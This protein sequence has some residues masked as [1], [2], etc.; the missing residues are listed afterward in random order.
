MKGKG[1]VFQD[2]LIGKGIRDGGGIVHVLN[3]QREP[4][5]CAQV[6]V[7]R[8]GHCQC[9]EPT[10]LLSGD[11]AERAG[12]GIKAQPRGQIPSACKR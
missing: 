1:R 3:G 4:G 6:T 9:Q 11:A 10:S 8:G 12:Q 2:G 7:V 5:R